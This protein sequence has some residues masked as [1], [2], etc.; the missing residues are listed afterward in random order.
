MTSSPWSTPLP[1]ATERRRAGVGAREQ[2]QAA[3]DAVP[4]WKRLLRRAYRIHDDERAWRRGAE[5]EE[6]V[7]RRLAKLPEGW[8]VLHD[9]CLRE[10]GTNLD[11]LVVGPAGVFVLNT[12]AL[13]GKVWVGDR[14]VMVNGR[15]TTYLR[16]ARW[17]ARRVGELLTA[18][19]APEV[20]ITPALVLVGCEVTVRS[21]PPDVEIWRRRDLP[22]LLTRRPRTVDDDLVR[23]LRDVAVRD[24]TWPTSAS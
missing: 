10:S 1:S 19:G 22:R 13:S 17:E 5:G 15:K 9:L 16:T 24:T 11:H 2:A 18:A 14:V 21:T 6:A 12:K 8:T 23:H 4:N 20:E 7:A 3:A